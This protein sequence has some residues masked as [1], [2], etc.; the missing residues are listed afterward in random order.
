[1]KKK[2]WKELCVD[3]AELYKHVGNDEQLLVKEVKEYLSEAGWTEEE[4]TTRVFEQ[5][6]IIFSQGGKL[7]SPFDFFNYDVTKN[8]N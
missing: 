1:M 3:I 7:D 4:W 5:L 6:N 8:M 2:S